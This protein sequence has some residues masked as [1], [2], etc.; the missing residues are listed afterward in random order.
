MKPLRR[1]GEEP[2]AQRVELLLHAAADWEPDEPAPHDLIARA[3]SRLGER[4]EVEERPE[5][6]PLWPRGRVAVWAGLFAG[7]GA[8]CASLA[9]ALT[10]GTAPG[11]APTRSVAVMPPPVVEQP[12][13]APRVR[14]VSDQMP[15][16]RQPRAEQPHVSTAPPPAPRPERRVVRRPS[17]PPKARWDVQPVER[18]EYAETA[19]DASPALL[20]EPSPDGGWRVEPGLIGIVVDPGVWVPLEEEHEAAPPSESKDM[21]NEMREEE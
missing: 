7:G 1:D 3:I 18:S 8:V 17:A 21:P 11:P 2:D 20:V 5:R 15:R 10:T 6:V 13:T 19:P 9:L 12:Q 4:E 16:I 14:L